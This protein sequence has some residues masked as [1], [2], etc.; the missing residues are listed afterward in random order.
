MSLITALRRAAAIAKIEIK[1]FVSEPTAAAFNNYHEI[2]R[3]HRIGVFDWGG[4]TLDVALIENKNGRIKE[5]ASGDLQLGG[6]DI[7]RKLAEWA[8]EKI[9]T[10]AG[11]D[12]PFEDMPA[13]ARD[14][15][16]TACEQAKRTLTD[17]NIAVIRTFK[18]GDLG[19]VFVT[20][21]I[22]TFSKIVEPEINR[23]SEFFKTV[24]RQASTSITELNCILLIGGS[25]NLRPFAELADSQWTGD[26]FRPS[27]SDWSVAGGAAGLNRSEG[28]YKTAQ[29]VGII[30]SD[31]EF[32]PLIDEGET[33]DGGTKEFEF[34]LVEDT[35]LAS[36]VFADEAKRRL[37]DMKVPSFGFFKERITI[38][39]RIDGDL[40]LNVTA[41]SKDRSGKKIVREKKYPGL[42]LDYQLPVHN[43]GDNGD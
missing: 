20:L 1:T 37:F 18:Y 13:E 4:G 32:F 23:A 31:D 9:A 3:Y 28:A 38:G 15:L 35:N 30:M 25:V 43:D 27:D 41:K 12:T 8:H 26:I 16:I 21:D 17:E 22:D 29:S 14:K 10:E 33:V 19:D 11:S 42:R 5:L 24:L 36:L 39:A 34:A 2:Q 6:D 40:V 7:D